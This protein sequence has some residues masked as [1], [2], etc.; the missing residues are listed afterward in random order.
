[1]R[2]LEEVRWN[3]EEIRLRPSSLRAKLLE[4][5][6][7]W[8][9]IEATFQRLVNRGVLELRDHE[10]ERIVEIDGKRYCTTRQ[11]WFAYVSEKHSL[12]EASVTNIR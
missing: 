1:M 4:R 9:R 8:T 2:L 5:G 6:H 12:Q 3:E 7:S 11:R 10:S